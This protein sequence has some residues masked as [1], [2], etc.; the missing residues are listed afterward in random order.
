MSGV[1]QALTLRGGRGMSALPSKTDIVCVPTGQ[2]SNR[3]W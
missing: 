1:G 3:W 2:D